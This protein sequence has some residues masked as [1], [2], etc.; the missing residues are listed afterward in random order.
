MALLPPSYSLMSEYCELYLRTT[1]RKVSRQREALDWLESR[2]SS[3]FIEIFRINFS[4]SC[5][6]LLGT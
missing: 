1:A 2:L 5:S 6:F 3:Q 4:N